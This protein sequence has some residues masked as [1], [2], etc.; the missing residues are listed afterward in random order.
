[1][2]EIQPGVTVHGA[3]LRDVLG[4]LGHAQSPHIAIRRRACVDRTDYYGRP[5]PGC[6]VDVQGAEVSRVFNNTG[7]ALVYLR[8]VL[9]EWDKEA[10]A[11]M[12]RHSK[13]HQ[14]QKLVVKKRP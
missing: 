12:Q 14:R 1:M 11:E 9:Q 5:S 7:E 10:H 8:G 6:V 4:L 13:S 2:G 3:N